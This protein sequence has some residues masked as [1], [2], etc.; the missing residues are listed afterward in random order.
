MD[1]FYELCF[2]KIQ[3]YHFQ[4]SNQIHVSKM[5]AQ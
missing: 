2:W 5:H 1:V 4:P 3:V